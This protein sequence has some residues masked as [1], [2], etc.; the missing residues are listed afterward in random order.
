MLLYIYFRE[1][2]EKVKEEQIENGRK[3]GE[4]I[5]DVTFWRNE[6]AS[7]LERLIVENGKMQDSRRKLQTVIQILEGQL[8]IAQECLYHRES[9]KGSSFFDII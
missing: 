9:R 6:V 1:V 2:D 8:H 7:E 3:L 5:T 4:R